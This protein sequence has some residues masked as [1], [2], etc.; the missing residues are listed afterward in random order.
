MSRDCTDLYFGHNCENVQDGMFCFNV[1]NLKRAIGNAEY[2]PDEY[3]KVK[4]SLLEQIS[5]EL[6]AK[7]TL[8]WDIYNIGC[9]G[10]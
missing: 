8:K 9:A 3:K 4:S 5:S 2:S 7:K 1:K 6:E 10:G